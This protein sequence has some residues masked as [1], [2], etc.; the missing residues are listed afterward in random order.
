[1]E[2]SVSDDDSQW[3]R[4]EKNLASA[5]DGDG[6]LLKVE[7]FEPA[8]FWTEALPLGNGKLGAMVFGGIPLDLI[9]LNGW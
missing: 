7:F 4:V 9:M 1:M 5:E 2:V 8:T 3:V 6:D